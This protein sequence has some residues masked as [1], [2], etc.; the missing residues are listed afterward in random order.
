M[1]Q[2]RPAGDELP[3]YADTLFAFH[4]AFRK[5]LTRTVRVVPRKARVLDVP[6]GDGFFTAALARRLHP[7]GSVV[8]ADLSD[9]YLGVAREAVAKVEPPC[10]VEFVKANAYKLPFDD[11][12]FD[13]VWCAQSLISLTDP[14]AALKEMRRVV[15][16]DGS[17]FVLEDDEFHRVLVNWP[18]E[19]ELAVQRGV[20]AASREK[21][22]SA[23]GLSPARRMRRWFVAAGLW[24]C[25]KRTFAADREAPFS[26]AVRKY[27][28]LHLGQTRDFIAPHLEA[29]ELAALDQAID[30]KHERSVFV[31]PDAAMTCLT[32]LFRAKK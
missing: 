8:A 13:H 24:P 6:C 26:P 20:A 18:V 7:H 17:V 2:T 28:R 22:E 9:A 19:V 11:D 23:A 21:Y 29:D 5:E 31:R 14:V 16:P 12:A 30:P 1:P 15:R 10:P 25:G 27:L 3:G 32:T 4:R